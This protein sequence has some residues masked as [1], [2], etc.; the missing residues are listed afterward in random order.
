MVLPP[1]N[2]KAIVAELLSPIDL[3]GDRRFVYSYRRQGGDDEAR[4]FLERLKAEEMGRYTKYMTA[5]RF[6]GMGRARGDVWHMLD[7]KDAPKGVNGSL[8]GI[9]EFKNIGHKSRIFHC[10]DGPLCV[11]LTKFEGKKED[12][13]PPEPLNRAI[14]AR[15]EYWKRRNLIITTLTR[16]RP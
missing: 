3:Q 7:P 1:D 9:G 10:N 16:R 11:L 5:I 13:L 8:D 6:F 4:E 14:A 12:D 15:D 2:L